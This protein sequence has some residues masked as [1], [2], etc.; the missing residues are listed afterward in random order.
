LTLK[1][2]A[3]AKATAEI[4]PMDKTLLLRAFDG[5]WS[6][7]AEIVDVFLSDYPKLM[8]DL[9]RASKEVDSDLLVRSAHSLKGMLKNFQA[10]SAAEIASVIE[11]KGKAENFADIQTDI[12][13]LADQISVVDKMLRSIVEQQAE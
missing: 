13:N 2:S 1:R 7:L 4:T 9:H 3:S 8:E 5:D 10:E 12:E 6:F 11:T